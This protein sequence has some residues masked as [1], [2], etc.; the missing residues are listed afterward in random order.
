MFQK[1]QGTHL[2]ESEIDVFHDVFVLRKEELRKITPK[3]I[4]VIQGVMKRLIAEHYVI[5]PEEAKL[6]KIPL[7]KLH[8]EKEMKPDSVLRF[9]EILE[10][11]GITTILGLALKT[12]LDLAGMSGMRKEYIEASEKIFHAMDLRLGV[13]IRQ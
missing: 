9:L 3:D 2:K 11:N 10:A 1:A 8:L 7:S 4:Q 6:L 5:D 13:K 12:P